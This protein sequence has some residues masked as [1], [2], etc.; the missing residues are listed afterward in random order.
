MKRVSPR[1]VNDRNIAAGAASAKL[2]KHEKGE[3]KRRYWPPFDRNL[4]RKRRSRPWPWGAVDMPGTEA[5]QVT[6]IAKSIAQKI[7][8]MGHLHPYAVRGWRKDRKWKRAIRKA[9]RMT[10]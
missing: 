4:P 8:E 7:E 5:Q 2:H 10:Q 1:T 6:R 9:R 3:P